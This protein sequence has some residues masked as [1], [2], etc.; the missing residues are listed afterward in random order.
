MTILARLLRD[1]RRSFVGWSLGVTALFAF[2]ASFYPSVRGAEAFEELFEQ[3]PETLRSIIGS[4]ESIPITT[5]PGYLQGRQFALLLPALLIIFAIGVGAS[6]VGGS[7]EDGTL[8]LLLAQPV[9]RARVLWERFAALV[10]L[11][12]GLG[13]VALA[14]TFVM[15][16]PVGLLEGVSITGLVTLHVAVVG[17]ALIHGTVA[18]AAGAASGR[19]GVGVVAG[20]VL[21]VGGYLVNTLSLVAAAAEPLR[22]VTPWHWYLGRNM[23][24]QGIAPDALILPVLV[25][26]LAAAAARWAFVRRD[27]R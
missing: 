17:L 8:E 25:V 4:V 12:V 6:A 24:V 20:S 26:G 21:A 13:T 7:E 9:T 18:F 5:P 1:R 3:L 22:L 15:A 14:G 27:L 2:S 19:G 11:V 23:L 16:P 10:V